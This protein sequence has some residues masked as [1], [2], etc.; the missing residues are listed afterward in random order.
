[1]SR[2]PNRPRLALGAVAL[3]AAL[4]VTGCGGTDPL[5]PTDPGAAG[6][7]VVGSQ[8]Y[9]SNE[10]VAELYAQ[11]LENAG[12]D[13]ERRYQIGQRD[14]YIP[15][16]E[17]GEVHVFP[18]YTGNLLQ[19]LEPGTT[20]TDAASV[21]SELIDALPDNL[22]PLAYATAQDADSYNITLEFSDLYGVTSLA[23]LAGVP[24][25]II[26]GGNPELAERPYGPR[27]LLEYY[28][29]E[30]EFVAIGDSGGPLTKQAI[31]DGTITMG[32]VYSADPDIATSDF[33]TLD[34]PE[35]MFL[36]Q[37]L[38]PIVS[39]DLADEIRAL[40]DAVS[41]KLT[42]DELVGL[43]LR[44]TSEQLSSAAIAT[45]WLTAMGLIS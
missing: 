33:V 21:Y 28:G 9:Y 25:P 17:S 42:T 8:A 2:T 39:A 6:T 34:D 44:S 45:A 22:V 16:L 31:S 30:V 40:L 4:T 20:S 1:M 13:V 5:A 32:D 12:Y 3:A 36:A 41:E 26:V 35:G 7:I 19:F 37:N 27:G 11:V 18:E 14:A 10:I 15:A 29:V 43:N 23:D 24:V 38:V